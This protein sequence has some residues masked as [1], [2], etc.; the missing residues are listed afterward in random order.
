METQFKIF[1]VR[2]LGTHLLIGNTPHETNIMMMI[3]EVLIA[4]TLMVAAVDAVEDGDE[5]ILAIEEGTMAG[6]IMV[7]HRSEVPI[8]GGEGGGVVVVLGRRLEMTMM[9][10]NINAKVVQ[11]VLLCVETVTTR[12]ETASKGE[13]S[14]TVTK[15]DAIT[16]HTVPIDRQ[17]KVR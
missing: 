7:V 2:R 3:T 1:E 15:R 17:D 6:V 13:D 4:T 14:K 11:E 9:I 8:C 10:M 16:F 12:L 5:A